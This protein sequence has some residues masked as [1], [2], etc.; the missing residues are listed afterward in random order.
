MFIGFAMGRFFSNLVSYFGLLFVVVAASVAVFLIGYRNFHNH[1]LFLGFLLL[2]LIVNLKL[3]RLL[4]FKNQV[5]MNIM[6]LRFLSDREKVTAQNLGQELPADISAL[7]IQGREYNKT[8]GKRPLPGKLLAALAALSHTR[9]GR[10]L[11]EQWA[12][13]QA[14][15]LCLGYLLLQWGIFLL[16]LLPFVLITFLFSS[17]MTGPSQILIYVLGVYFVYFLNAGIID[18]ILSLLMQKRLYFFE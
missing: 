2:L 8:H 14:W 13:H 15:R 3:R 4:F 6:F 9:E 18:P 5:P 17:Y 11:P 7:L 1:Y 12:L 10:A 16:I